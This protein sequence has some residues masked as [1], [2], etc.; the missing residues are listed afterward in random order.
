M[1][2]PDRYVNGDYFRT[3]PTW[4]SED[5]PWKAEQIYKIIQRN[6]LHPKSICE[7][8]CGAGEILKQLQIILNDNCNFSGYEISPQAYDL[9]LDKTN[10]NL[11]FKLKDFML[12][13]DVHYDILLLIDVIE[14]LEDYFTYLRNIKD[15]SEYKIFHIPLEFFTLATIFHS[16]IL[17]QRNNV[18]HLHYFSKEIVLQILKDADYEII[19]YFYTGG[20]S[21]GH[22]YGIKDKLV[23]IPRKYLFPLSN[24][25]TVRIFGGYSIMVLAK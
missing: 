7:V 24:D 13:E 11:N 1:N 12:E 21:L 2:I 18:G 6:N 4:D 23:K 22:N 14:H 15:K 3:N 19:D 20:Y 16:F 10:N 17:N 9:C 5:S 25:L 8:G